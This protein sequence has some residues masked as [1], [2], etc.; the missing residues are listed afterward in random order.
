MVVSQLNGPEV[1]RFRRPAI[2]LVNKDDND[3]KEQGCD[4][5]GDC[6]DYHSVM[7]TGDRGWG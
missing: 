3:D 1:E 4:S 5:D 2:V 6:D 7:M